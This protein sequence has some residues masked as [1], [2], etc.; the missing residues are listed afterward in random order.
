MDL[1]P[2][3]DE[4][5]AMTFHAGIRPGLERITELCSHLDEPH[6][7]YPVIHVAGTNGKGSTCS[8]LASILTHA[9]YKVGLYTSPHIRQFNERIRINGTMISDE[10]V[11]RLARPLMDQA[12]S[13][14]GTFFEVTT[15]M[16][17]QYF[18]ERRVEVAII[19]TGLGGRFDATNIVQPFLSIITQIDI[20]HTEYLGTTLPQIAGEKA[21]I[22]KQGAPVVIGHRSGIVVNGRPVPDIRDVFV[23]KAESANTP[24]SFAEDT[25]YVEMDAIHPDLTMT[26]SVTNDADRK[27]Y[28]TDL[29]GQHQT[30][31]IATVIAAL[32]A[33]SELYFVEEPHIREGL[34]R[35]KSTSGLYGR[36]DLIN[37]DPFTVIDVSHNPGGIAALRDTLIASGKTSNSMQV[38]FGAMSDKDVAGMID[39]IAPLAHTLHLCS[40]AL[41]RALAV[42]ELLNLALSRG[43]MNAVAHSSVAHAYKAAIAHGPTVVC[44]SFHVIDEVML[45]C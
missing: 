26:V 24:I 45:M 9:G 27:Y 5:F 23:R 38:V 15:A 19:E 31:N 1:K 16:A 13:F 12:K 2:I 28:T 17:F 44:G 22:I 34:L 37:V 25:I 33:I 32:P 7:R 36:C 4:L 6:L 29:C 35:V 41:P 14:G 20:D 43:I 18:A 42:E 39:A 30:S 21:G 40:P 11:A 8:M 3:L 10:D